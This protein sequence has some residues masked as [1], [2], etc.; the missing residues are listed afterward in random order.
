MVGRP[1]EDCLMILSVVPLLW[2]M[3]FVFQDCQTSVRRR[4]N[5]F[6][7]MQ[8]SLPVVG[9]EWNARPLPMWPHTSAV[10]VCFC[11]PFRRW[12]I[13]KSCVLKRKTS[14]L[15]APH[16]LCLSSAHKFTDAQ[17]HARNAFATGSCRT[18]SFIF[19][20]RWCDERSSLERFPP[21]TSELDVKSFSACY[22]F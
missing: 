17:M 22:F 9:R 14:L 3:A 10:A 8:I 21:C 19:S 7:K 1:L 6:S 11:D 12:G 16:W 18:A 15:V 13:W 20:R 4:G 5:T 2:L